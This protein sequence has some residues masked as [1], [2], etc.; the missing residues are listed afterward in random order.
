MGPSA[1]DAPLGGILQSAVDVM[2]PPSG[3]L[4]V[5]HSSHTVSGEPKCLLNCFCWREKALISRS[6]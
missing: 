2:P 4:P 5:R 3:I 6:P 1:C